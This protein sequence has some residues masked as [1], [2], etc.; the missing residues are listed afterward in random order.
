MSEYKHTKPHNSVGGKLE[1]MEGTE[2]IFTNSNYLIDVNLGDFYI[3]PSSLRHTV[4]P[5][6]SSSDVNERISFS[7]NAK[8]V[9]DEK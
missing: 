6:H 3:F 1:F 4:Y 9:F 5:F 7:F 8:I 2:D